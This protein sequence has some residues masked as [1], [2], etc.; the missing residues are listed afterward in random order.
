MDSYSTDGTFEYLKNHPRVKVVQREFKNYTDQKSY[1]LGLASFNWVYFLDA[2]EVVPVKLQHEIKQIINVPSSC[3]AYWNYRSFM[4]KNKR[5]YFSGWQTDKVHRLF[6]KEQC[7][8]ADDRTVHETLIIQ[9]CTGK[10]K[11]KLFHYSYKNYED[12]KLKMIKYG[13]LKAVD[14]HRRGKRWNYF[15]QYVNPGWKFINHYIIRLGILDGKKGAVM[16]YLNA[17]GVWEKYAEL[18]RLESKAS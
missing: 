1:T 16:C 6:Q 7:R 9:G 4:F 12:Y 17:L 2:D 8:F 10:L 11:E 5:L 14:A 13:R 18:K 3:S 15:N